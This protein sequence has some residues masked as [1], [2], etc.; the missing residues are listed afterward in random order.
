MVP[1]WSQN[2]PKMVPKLSENGLGLL[3]RGYTIWGVPKIMGTFLGVPI[4]RTTVFW[5]LYWG[6]YMKVSK[7]SGPLL[8]VPTIRIIAYLGPFWARL[9]METSIW[10]LLFVEGR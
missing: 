4:I 5:G 7:N 2:G 10:L 1:K 9:F 8:V 3:Y 6:G